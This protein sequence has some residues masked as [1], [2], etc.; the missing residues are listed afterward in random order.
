MTTARLPGAR[1]AAVAR[2][3]RAKPPARPRQRG[4]ALLTAMILV[5]LVATLSSA[6]VWQQWRAV[7][8]E[9]AERSRLQSAWILS[10][11]LD[12]SR[13][14]LREDARSQR[15][16]ALTEPWAT[17]LAE[18]R[19]ST[20]LAA[21]KERTD[22]APE[23]FLAG[24]ITDAQAR[25]NLLNVVDGDKVSPEG[26]AVLQ[27]L[28]AL[29]GAAD[30]LAAQ[31]AERLRDALANAQTQTAAA[32]LVPQTTAQI[33]WLGADADTLRR[34]TPLVTVLPVVTPVNLNTAS[35]EV[36]AAA[37]GIDLGSADRIVQARQRTPFR[38]AASVAGL[39]P[40][41]TTL[42][43]RQVDF[44][45]SFFEITGR[46]RLGERVLYERSLVQRRGLDVVTLRRERIGPDEVGG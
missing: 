44:R 3:R 5:T 8:V 14:I 25:F 22:D 12:W 38:D 31:L 37:A 11:A 39:L 13:L 10:G 15:P 24:A 7:Q 19:L 33:A 43:A 40:A 26:V 30:G 1:P 21:D 27:R 41:N 2:R 16:T 46:L 35:R 28:C 9:A 36:L 29:A 6:M 20:F 34:L 42:N 17:P 32:P 18:A 23:A 4:A 45:S